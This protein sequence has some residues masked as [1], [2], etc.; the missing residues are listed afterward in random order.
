[1]HAGALSAEVEGCDLVSLGWSGTEIASRILVTVRDES[2]GSVGATVRDVRV[3]ERADGATARIDARHEDPDVAFAWAGFVELRAGELSFALEGHALREFVYRRI[4]ICVLHPWRAYVGARYRARTPAGDLEGTFPREI[5]PQPFVDG[6]YRPMIDAFSELHV[7]LPDGVALDARFEGELFELEDQRNWTDASFKT[8]PTPLARSE[9]RTMRE[10][11]VVRQRVMVRISGAPTAV[12]ADDGPAVVR[13]GEPTGLVMPPVGVMLPP[14][15]ISAETIASLRGIA[16]AHVRGELLSPD[17]EALARLAERGAEIGA[18][19]ELALIVDDDAG[20][21]ALASAL[22]NVRLTR[23]LV[24]LR[25]GATIQG[26]LVNDVRRRL[27]SSIDGV[28]VAG[29]T[30]SHF[31]ELNRLRPDL[32]GV[33]EMALSMSSQVHAS[34][35]RSMMETLEI[36]GE[37]VR[38]VR[39]IANRLPVVVSPVSLLPHEPGGWEQDPRATQPFGAAWVL[40]SLASLARGGAASI[41]YDAISGPLTAFPGSDVLEVSISEPGSVAALALRGEEGTTLLLANLTP[42]PMTVDVGETIELD[43]YGTKDIEST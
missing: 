42:A 36:Q 38:S 43:G 16:P 4:G 22:Q 11:E 32:E 8:Y 17:V 34:D 13:V 20:V 6:A 25:S 23:L 28:P 15:P 37:I 35:E 19:L 27:G 24:H 1:M 33:D 40:G 21:S 9:P 39:A 26:E 5:A 29:G 14:E 10:G 31:S 30:W 3:E 2:W 12:T 7:E 18:P 41:T